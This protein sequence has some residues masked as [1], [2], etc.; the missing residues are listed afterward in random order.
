VVL[1][2][3][4]AVGSCPGASDEWAS[5]SSVRSSV[6]R[7]E[8]RRRGARKEAPGGVEG[9]AGVA[10]GKV[11]IDQTGQVRHPRQGGSVGA[12]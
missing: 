9:F 2:C 3:K 8:R 5:S 6:C 11:R 4:D 7:V 12:C 10:G 1:R